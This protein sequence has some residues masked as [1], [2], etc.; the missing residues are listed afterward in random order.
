[1]GDAIDHSTPHTHPEA[2]HPVPSILVV[3][4]SPAMREVLEEVLTSAGYEVT[5]VASGGRA[6]EAM[7]A[8]LPSLVII[9]LL[10]PGMSGFTLRSLMLRRAELAAIPV[11]IVS[12]FWHRPG[13]TLDAALVLPKPISVD[14]LLE[15]VRQLVGP[16]RPTSGQPFTPPPASGMVDASRFSD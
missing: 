2:C 12:G 16:A 4:D 7:A 8:H 3:D 10:M 11:I 5:G 9:D 14:R 1:M 13:E 6:L 15:G